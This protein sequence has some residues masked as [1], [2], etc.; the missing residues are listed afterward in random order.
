[1]ARAAAAARPIGAFSAHA[2]DPAARARGF[3]TAALLADWPAIVGAEL[4]RFTMPDRVVWPRHRDDD[5]ESVRHQGRREDGAVL[6]L[7]V[8]G[9][10]AIEVQHRSRQILERVNGHFGYRAVAEM[11]ILQAPVA[12]KPATAPPPEPI[13]PGALPASAEAIEDGGLREALKRLAS[14]SRRGG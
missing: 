6:I 2:L 13:A 1:M 11:R 8:D 5:G 7:R 9:P 3:A 4:A 10:R 12:R 14:V